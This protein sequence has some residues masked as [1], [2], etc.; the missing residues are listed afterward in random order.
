MKKKLL[1]YLLA[2]SLLLVAV[3]GMV[4]CS[5]RQGNGTDDPVTPDDPE[6]IKEVNYYLSKVNDGLDKTKKVIESEQDPLKEYAVQSEYTFKTG[7]ENYTL[8]FDCVYGAN[9][10]KDK[11]YVRLFDNV[12]HI[13]RVSLYYDSNDL[14]VYSDN[15]RYKIAD[16]NSLLL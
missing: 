13:T 1:L 12:N 16:F 8:R 3:L 15:G 14:Y 9:P 10:E 6:P 11:Y 4:A 5:N 2:L 7:I